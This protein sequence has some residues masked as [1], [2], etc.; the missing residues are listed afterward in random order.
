MCHNSPLRR[1][2]VLRQAGSAVL[3]WPGEIAILNIE[4]ILRSE[5]T[6][7]RHSTFNIEFE[8]EDEEE[9]EK[10]GK[11]STSNPSFARKLRRAGIQHPTS[12]IEQPTTSI[13]K[14]LVKA[15]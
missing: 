4:P 8:D 10:E 6:E 3:R 14:T 11:R 9:D 13:R 7:G 5:A 15:G 12:N 1:E 2:I